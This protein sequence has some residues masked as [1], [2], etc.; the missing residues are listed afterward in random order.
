MAD[1]ALKFFAIISPAG[2]RCRHI[3]YRPD[4][5]LR[6][7]RPVEVDGVPHMSNLVRLSR[8][9]PVTCKPVPSLQCSGRYMTSIYLRSEIS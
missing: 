3:S 2:E 4:G 6:K 8:A 5:G 1:V 9:E 7:R